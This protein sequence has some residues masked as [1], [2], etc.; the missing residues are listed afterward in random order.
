[1]RNPF[2]PACTPGQWLLRSVCWVVV[3][4]GGWLLASSW[5]LEEPYNQK[6]PAEPLFFLSFAVS[7]GL[8]W[9]KAL[10][11][12]HAAKKD[13]S[14]LE[15]LAFLWLVGLVIFQLLWLG[16]MLLLLAAPF[17]YNTENF[18]QP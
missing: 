11:G 10:P 13:V 16:L 15:M 2:S 4:V 18:N 1:M 6:T 3:L 14:W 8:L 7:H 17:F 12:L 9:W 5:V